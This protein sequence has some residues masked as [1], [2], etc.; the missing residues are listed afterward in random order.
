MRRDPLGTLARTHARHGPIVGVRI[1]TRVVTLVAQPSY[2]DATV[3]R[4]PN[5]D[6]PDVSAKPAWLRASA[7]DRSRFVA[8]VN[9][10]DHQDRMGSLLAVDDMVAGIV[11]TLEVAGELDDT[12]GTDRAARGAARRARRLRRSHL[13]GMR[14]SGR[15]SW[16]RF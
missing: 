5:F 16:A 12:R 11:E 6:E 2:I 8:L 14:F 7:E 13:P 1:G 3:P 4:N 9:D 15:G 10:A